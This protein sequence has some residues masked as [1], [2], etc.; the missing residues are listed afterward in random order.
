MTQRPRGS[1][2][3]PL[4]TAEEGS[5]TGMGGPA[6]Q[7]LRLGRVQAPFSFRCTYVFTVE[8]TQTKVQFM[9]VWVPCLYFSVAEMKLLLNV[10]YVHID[11]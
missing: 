7:A 10:L 2:Q 4:R 3:D 1:D 6:P 8:E 9:R 11:K 5:L